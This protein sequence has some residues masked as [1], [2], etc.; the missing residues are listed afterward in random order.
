MAAGSVLDVGCGTGSM[1]Q[2]ARERG[3]AGRLAGLGPQGLGPQGL[4]PQGLSAQCCG[5]DPVIT[6]DFCVPSGRLGRAGDLAG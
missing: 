3:H 1:L 4:G 6:D 2:S 5:R